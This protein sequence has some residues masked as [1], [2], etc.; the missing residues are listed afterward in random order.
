MNRVESEPKD[1]RNELLEKLRELHLA[2]F[3]WSL[4]CC[5]GDRLEA[6]E[7]LQT[8]YLKVLDGRARFQGRSSLKTWVFSVIRATAR[9]S[10]RSV[11][12]RLQAVGRYLGHAQYAVEAQALADV[13]AAE[14][15]GKIRSLLAG[16]SERQRETVRLVFYH[17]LSVEEAAEVMGVSVGAARRHYERAKEN[18]RR[19]CGSIEVTYD[20]ERQRDQSAVQPG[21]EDRR[22][23][24][25][26]T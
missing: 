3:T 24:R 20:R 2:C 10:Q 14:V 5:R 4:H 9:E 17:D 11:W 15:K 6:E 22:S 19:N 8:V 16:L 23:V 25:A 21:T 12:R 18:L 1:E 7:A 13:Y 26:D